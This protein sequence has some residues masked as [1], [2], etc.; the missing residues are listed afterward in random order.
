MAT[1]L[2]EITG[3]LDVDQ[4]WPNGESDG[5]T[6]KVVVSAGSFRFQAKPSGKWKVTHAFAG[7]I[8]KRSLKS[9]TGTTAIN[10]KNQITVR[11]QGIDAP[12]LHYR[13][14]PEKLTTKQKAALKKV[15]GNFRQ[16]FGESAAV[17]LGR[18]LAKL[19]KNP[20]PITIRTAVDDPSE[21]FDMYGRLIGD[22]YVKV[23]GKEVDLNH[24]MLRQG[25]AFPTL[26]ASMSTDEITDVLALAAKAK[27]RKVGLWKHAS[28]ALKGFDAK[29]LFVKNG[30]FDAAK[31]AGPV[32]MPKQFRRLSTYSVEKK[33][34]I[35]SG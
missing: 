21:V 22:L 24:W 19:G 31:D 13:P 32:T 5:D 17:A 3:T 30:A 6:A 34:K 18:Y 4:F 26:Y 11:W 28:S 20:V 35:V 14:T 2:L 33:S 7:A 10:A 8:V 12:E 16:L 29:L 25:W 27:A 1:G 15:N 23:K 9:K